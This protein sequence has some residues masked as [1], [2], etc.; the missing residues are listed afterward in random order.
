MKNSLVSLFLLISAPIFAQLTV[1]EKF[2]KIGTVPE[3]Q[4]FIDANPALKPALL[5][6]SSGKDTSTFEKRL[7]RQKKGD[8]FSVGYTTYKVL[9]ATE[10]IAYRANYI[11]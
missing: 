11:F 10:T 5:H 1:T 9:E 6:L 7:L 2:Q 3:A 8:I 4:Q